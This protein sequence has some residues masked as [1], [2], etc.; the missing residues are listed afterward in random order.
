MFGHV[1]QSIRSVTRAD[2][3]MLF[4]AIQLPDEH[5]LSILDLDDEIDAETEAAIYQGAAIHDDHIERRGRRRSPRGMRLSPEEYKDIRERL[6]EIGELGEAIFNDWITDHSLAGEI[7]NLGWVSREHAT[8]AFDFTFIERD[9]TVL[10]DVKSTTGDFERPIH[11]S[12]AEI[13]AAAEEVADGRYAIACIYSIRE[14][15]AYMRIL[16]NFRDNAREIVEG[17]G[18]P[19][20]AT[21]DGFSVNPAALAFGKEIAI[22]LNDVNLPD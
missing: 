2:L 4:N 19:V 10:L 13:S 21:T 11:L 3:A 17:I 14:D 20:W 1:R 6:S 18:M 22:H 15:R 9:I 7:R 16:S 8:A 12:Y 5:P